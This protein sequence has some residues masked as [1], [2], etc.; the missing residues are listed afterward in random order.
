MSD[1]A[2]LPPGNIGKPSRRDVGYR[3]RHD[4][5]VYAAT[6]ATGIGERGPTGPT[7]APGGGTGPTGPAGAPS[8]VTG[9]TGSKG[10]TGAQG[11]AADVMIWKGNV[12]QA[13]IAAVTAAAENGFFYHCTENI[14]YGALVAVTNDE[15]V[16]VEDESR[17]EI[18]GNGV[19]VSITGPTGP[20][21]TGPTGPVGAASTVTGPT[22]V[23]PTGPKGDTGSKGD[24]GA[25]SS[26]VGPTGP[27]GLGATGPVG[28]AST[29]TGPT[30]AQGLSI[31]GPTGAQGAA[32]SASTVTGPTGPTGQGVTGP[33]GPASTVTGPT[34]Y[35]GAGSTGPTG[36]QGA[37][38][39][40]STVTGPTGYTGAGSTGPTGPS[41]AGSTGPTGPVGATGAAGG[42]SGDGV[43]PYIFKATFNASGQLASATTTG[44]SADELAFGTV[45]PGF[46]VDS[47]DTANMTISHSVNKPLKFI[48]AAGHKAASPEWNLRT[49]S[50]TAVT[51][52]MVNASKAGTFRLVTV[53]ATNTGSENSGY[54]IIVCYF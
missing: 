11:T 50:A 22:G 17:W 23:G 20:E 16:W 51:P 37:A 47:I 7:G 13:T 25:D 49:F 19:A 39:A 24:T 15:I 54:A 3:H 40:A 35:T 1:G 27:T 12:S 30:G 14:T 5:V 4:D 34:G 52:T 28:P 8:T 53:S 2:P 10:D 31:T 9:P 44:L 26:V 36:A 45:L 21:V 32:G 38:G 43:T 41:G 48:S 6:G 42:G 33:V 46:V 18:V 29:I